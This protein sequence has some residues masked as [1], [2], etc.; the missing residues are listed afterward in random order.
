LSEI[1]DLLEIDGVAACMAELRL[2]FGRRVQQLLQAEAHRVLGLM[3]PG[4]ALAA[5][6]MLG[7]GSPGEAMAVNDKPAS[8]PLIRLNGLTRSFED[9]RAAML[10]NEFDGPEDLACIDEE[11]DD[12][13]APAR[14]RVG[15][16]RR[17]SAH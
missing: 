17:P 16:A 15:F 8:Q 10:A 6:P 13:A 5:A 2:R 3:N 1:D 11:P 4:T 7:P 9:E 14:I 12:E